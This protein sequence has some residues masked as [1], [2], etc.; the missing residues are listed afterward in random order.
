VARED[1]EEQSTKVIKAVENHINLDLTVEKRARKD[2]AIALR[3]DLEAEKRMRMEAQT[4]Y[5]QTR[6]HHGDLKEHRPRGGGSRRSILTS[7]W[8]TRFADLCDQVV[9]KRGNL[10]YALGEARRRVPRP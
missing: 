8:W 7:I 2:L 3:D 6:R 9:Q 5:H 10:E 1:F 4:V